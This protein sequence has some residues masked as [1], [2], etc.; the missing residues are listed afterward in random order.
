MEKKYIV[1]A[2]KMSVEQ[3]II[4]RADLGDLPVLLEFEQQ[5]I[6]AERPMDKTI[7]KGV[8]HYYDLAALLRDPKARVVVAEV[9][10]RAVASGFARIKQARP[11]LDHGEYAY[12]GFMYTDPEHR[13]KGINA[14][15]VD[16][17]KQWAL[18][19]GL[20]EVRL[21]VYP[22][23]LPAI[24][25]YEKVGFKGHILEMRLE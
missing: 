9:G 18:D 20:T 1:N 13:G 2:K 25:A 16:A 12:L 3:P 22:G 5:I 7:R 19:R 4:R 21:T 15:I 6:Q 14:Q 11:Y 17:L 10:G 24:R 23:N 8:V